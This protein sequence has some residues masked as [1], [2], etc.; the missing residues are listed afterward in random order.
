MQDAEFGGGE[1]EGCEGLGVS[2]EVR[3]HGG[4]G[5]LEGGA[6]IRYSAFLELLSIVCATRR[7]IQMYDG[8]ANRWF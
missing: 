3:T 8:R 4:V 2:A 6:V 7:T 5:H 1:R